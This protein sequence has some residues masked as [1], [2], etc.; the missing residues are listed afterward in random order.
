MP[1]ACSPCGVRPQTP[2]STACMLCDIDVDSCKN[3]V[4]MLAA[5]STTATSNTA[6]TDASTTADKPAPWICCTNSQ[7]CTTPH[8]DEFCIVSFNATRKGLLCAFSCTCAHSPTCCFKFAKKAGSL[9]CRNSHCSSSMVWNKYT[10]MTTTAHPHNTTHAN[11][12]KDITRATRT[13]TPGREL[14]CACARM[15][16]RN[17]LGRGSTRTHESE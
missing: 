7:H 1:P 5:G 2:V 13:A 17:E 11:V 9:H 12:A 8:K 15:P 16:L 4:T 14:A 6:A 3:R 10:R